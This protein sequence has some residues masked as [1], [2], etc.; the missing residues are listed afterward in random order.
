MVIL[1]ISWLTLATFSMGVE[2]GPTMPRVTARNSR[3]KLAQSLLTPLIMRADLRFSLSIAS[4][5]SSLT[6]ILIAGMGGRMREGG[7]VEKR[8]GSGSELRCLYA[9]AESFECH[10]QLAY[11]S[12][13]VTLVGCGGT[14]IVQAKSIPLP[15]RR[16]MVWMASSSNPIQSGVG[17][18]QS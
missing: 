10:C 8:T 7:G 18:N 1:T 12:S 14:A 3:R 4:S 2:C 6:I 13:G 17:W 5:L 11:G 9:V 15:W 16:V